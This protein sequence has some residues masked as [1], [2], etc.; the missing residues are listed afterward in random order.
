MSEAVFLNGLIFKLPRE[1][2]PDFVKGSLSIKREELIEFLR[3]HL[4]VSVSLTDFS[5]SGGRYI[6]SRVAISL[7]DEYVTESDDT[8][9]VGD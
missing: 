7:D 1:N 2:A 3:E 6:N 8:V 9:W 4:T 5:E